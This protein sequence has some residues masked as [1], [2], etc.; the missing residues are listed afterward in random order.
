MYLYSIPILRV[1]V[2]EFCGTSC[3]SR[4]L[5]TFCF[6]WIDSLCRQVQ[7][8]KE[9]DRWEQILSVFRTVLSSIDRWKYSRVWVYPAARGI[10]PAPIPIH[11]GM[12][13]I[14][15]S[16]KIVINQVSRILT[17]ESAPLSAPGQVKVTYSWH[18]LWTTKLQTGIHNIYIVQL[19]EDCTAKGRPM[20]RGR[21]ENCVKRIGSPWHWYPCFPNPLENKTNIHITSHLTIYLYR[22]LIIR[23]SLL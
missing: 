8:E 23:N 15:H 19:L 22:V 7:V 6:K 12:Y 3:H 18:R 17:S 20:L 13:T 2:D 5:E 10:W 14:I 9:N 21:S 1:R 11:R 4:R 16:P